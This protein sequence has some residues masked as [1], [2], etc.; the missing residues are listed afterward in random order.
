MAKSKTDPSSTS[1]AYDKM[2]PRWRLM[3]TV[4]GGTEALREAAQEYLPKHEA[5]T[6]SS[7]RHRLACAV[8]LNR[9]EQTLNNL[10]SKPFADGLTVGEDVPKEISEGILDNVDLLGNNLEVFAKQW[11]RTG[12]AKGFCHVLIDFPRTQDKPD[13]T[14]R[15]L[16]DDRAEQLRPYWVLIEPENVLFAR[17]E[18]INGKEVLEHVRII[19][20]VTEQDG[21]IER[22]VQQIRVLE[23]N[24]TMIYRKNG[25]KKWTKVEEWETGLSF[26]PLV[27]FYAQRD[28]F[29][30]SKPPLL[31]LA[32]LNIAHWQ[33]TSDQRHILTVS[34]FPI[35]ACS[36]A[37][38]DDSDPLKI[39]PNNILYNPDPSGR[40]YYVEH[41]GNAIDAGAQELKDLEDQMAGYGAEFL[42][43]KSGGQTATARALDS[44]EALSDLA[45][46][47][48]VFEDAV[49]VALWYTGSWMGLEDGGTIEL[50]KDFNNERVAI[51]LDTL[52]KARSRKDI[53]R[54]SYLEGLVREG[55]LPETFDA[56]DD[57]DNLSEETSLLGLGATSLN[58]DP[59]APEPDKDN[60][61]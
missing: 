32:H 24:K 9:T 34:R 42:K 20:T 47:V 45:G 55:V 19:E 2:S 30:L 40:F 61:A 41:S 11:F 38:A 18:V 35:L 57:L 10:S 37:T 33:S 51:N 39:S 8:F 59:T 49:S 44:S 29:M 5:E 15:T 4:L 3:R 54:K 36:G 48:M 58:L 52:D 12:L 14:P 53:S 28:D 43:R 56:D 22:E 21:F 46:M 60:V 50:L 26:I 31:D 6:D 27:T 25:G 16:A 17:A 13:G 23:P 7:Y 1:I